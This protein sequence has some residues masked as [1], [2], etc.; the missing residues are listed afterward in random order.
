MDLP[1]NSNT[2]R[3]PKP[4]KLERITTGEVTRRKKPLG[5]RLLGAFIA[6]D[7]KQAATNAIF[8]VFLPAAK[9]MIVDMFTRGVEEWFYGDA[10][11]ARSRTPN[12]P[13]GGNG[14]VS[15]NRFSSP[16]TSARREEGR[17]FGRPN[18]LA[19]T[20]DDLVVGTRA[21]AE[22]I[23][24]RMFDIV[25][26]YEQATVHDLYELVGITGEPIDTKLGWTSMEGATFRRIGNGYLLL[27]P[28]IEHLK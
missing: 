6:G 22:S 15:Y 3:A 23:I 4:E 9:D 10:R 2:S 14:Y 17:S 11:S 16:A 24:D 26:K 12:R 21:E 27:L 19:E 7:P 20:L 13:T 8:D 18:R 28:K 5:S 1:S 25:G